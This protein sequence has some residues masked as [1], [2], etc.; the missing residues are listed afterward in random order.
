[1]LSSLPVPT[2]Q[3]VTLNRTADCSVL[4]YMSG[5]RGHAPVNYAQTMY[6]QFTDKE[7]NTNGSFEVFFYHDALPHTSERIGDKGFYW[8]PCFPGCLPDGD[9]VGPFKTEQAAIKDATDY[10]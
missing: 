1:M 2:L 4:S 10:I 6:H 9:P 7:G 8:W 3:S 5:Q